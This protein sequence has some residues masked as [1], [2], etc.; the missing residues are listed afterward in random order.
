MFPLFLNLLTLNDFILIT[1]NHWTRAAKVLNILSLHFIAVPFLHRDTSIYH[2]VQIICFKKIT[3]VF[4]GRFKAE[5]YKRLFAFLPGRWLL[6]SNSHSSRVCEPMGF[7]VGACIKMEWLCFI[8][9][10]GRN[11][12]KLCSFILLTIM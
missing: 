9:R 4:I 8:V 7:N 11:L 1:N 5:V 3:A 10:F 12:S 6:W 2:F